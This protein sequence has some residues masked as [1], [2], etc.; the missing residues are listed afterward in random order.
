MAPAVEAEFTFRFG[1]DI[2]PKKTEFTKDFV[3]KT[4]DVVIPSIELV[5]TV[6]AN[7]ESVSLF[8]IV[9][10]NSSNSGLFLSSKEF[11]LNEKVDLLTTQV[12]LSIDGEV[13]GSG[14]GKDVLGDPLNSLTWLVNSLS[15]RNIPIKR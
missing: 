13:K 5:D 14:T 15:A 8:S 3:K 4:V 11:P 10:D 9:A 6:Y 1:E 7:K 12:T 2:L